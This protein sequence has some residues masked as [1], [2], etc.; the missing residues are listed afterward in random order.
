MAQ[1]LLLR[2]DYEQGLIRYESRFKALTSRAQLYGT[3]TAQEWDGS[4]LSKSD[5]LLIIHEQGLGDTIMFMRYALYLSKQGSNI[6]LLVPEKLQALLISSGLNCYS[7][8]TSKTND[9]QVN[10]W[11]PMLTLARHLHVTPSNPLITAPY[12][13]V[14]TERLQK[15]KDQIKTDSKKV[16]VGINWQGNP[17]AEK[18]IFLR[19]RS[20]RLELFSDLINNF[21]DRCQF[22]SLQKG[23]G[24]D[25][26]YSCSFKHQFFKYQDDFGSELDLLDSAAIVS[27]CDL[28][29]TTDTMIAHLA[30][31]IGKETWV[32]LN[33]VPEW[34][35]GLENES[36]FWYPKTRLFRQNDQRDWESVFKKVIL[37]L[38]KLLDEKD[39]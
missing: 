11:T 13:N 25:Q 5:H 8:S 3:C 34:R 9:I 15:W 1:L 19:G 2:G 33:F 31:A 12:I 27:N 35:W 17:D 16:I 32:L 22:V 24:V 29:I 26:I 10:K 20:I 6:S 37:N 4:S 18:N 7:N 38:S 21:A 36:S 23:H 30:G 14:P 39:K 28:I